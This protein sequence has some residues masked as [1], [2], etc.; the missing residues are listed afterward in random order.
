MNGALYGG[1]SAEKCV[2]GSAV[3]GVQ[4][5]LVSSVAVALSGAGM[6]PDVELSSLGC[7]LR[8]VSSDQQRRS[9]VH[10]ITA[11]EWCV[12]FNDRAEIAAD[13]ENVVREPSCYVFLCCI[14]IFSHHFSCFI[15]PPKIA[16]LGA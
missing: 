6:V 5:L 10:D 2:A 11:G 12:V 7:V 14:L 1:A 13:V 8:S 9:T 4:L 15:L 16:Y 3:V